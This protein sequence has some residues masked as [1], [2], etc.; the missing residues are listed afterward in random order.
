MKND[1]VSP[2]YNHYKGGTARPKGGPAIACQ[3][4]ESGGLKL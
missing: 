4:Q 3:M 2:V 1:T